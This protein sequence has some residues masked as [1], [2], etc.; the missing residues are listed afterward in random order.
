MSK[1]TSTP[2][3]KIALIGSK[4]IN[5]LNTPLVDAK[6]GENLI[7]EI[8]SE[9]IIFGRANPN[10][11]PIALA[12]QKHY[13]YFVVGVD[14]VHVGTF[15]NDKAVRVRYRS[16]YFPRRYD[17]ALQRL[18]KDTSRSFADERI[19]PMKYELKAPSKTQTLKAKRKHTDTYL[20]RVASGAVV[21]KRRGKGASKSLNP[22]R[23]G[24]LA[25]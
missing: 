7:L 25:A 24:K 23:R 22:Y 5:W 8:T 2:K 16:G 4:E 21:P 6:K 1:L 17:R 3:S 20:K 11:C 14:V 18:A 12:G 15:I 19:K 9:E 10:A 13:A